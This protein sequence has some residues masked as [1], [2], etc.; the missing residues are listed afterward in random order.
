MPRRWVEMGVGVG[1][2]R[3]VCVCVCVCV[4]VWLGGGG[5]VIR[6]CGIFCVSS[7]IFSIFGVKLNVIHRRN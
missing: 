3:E 4:C 1:K 7:F 2:V 5:S 6:Q